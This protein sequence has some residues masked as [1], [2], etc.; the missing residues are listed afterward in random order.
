MP[1][2]ARLFTS[3]AGSPVRG[4]LK[5]RA[6]IPPRWIENARTSRK[7]NEAGIVSA[8]GKLRRLQKY[9]PRAKA[10]I[11]AATSELRAALKLWETAYR[12]EV[13]YRGIRVLLE[14]KRDGASKL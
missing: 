6:N 1:R 7:R 12:K 8:L 10:R 5:L 14:I 3:S 9:H 11:R 2:E 4:F 13:F